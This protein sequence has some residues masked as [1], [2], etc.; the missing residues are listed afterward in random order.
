MSYQYNHSNSYQTYTNNAGS[1]SIDTGKEYNHTI[2]NNSGSASH[3]V[4][5]GTVGDII[6]GTVLQ[7]GDSPVVE[8]NGTPI[9]VRSDVL[10]SAKKGDQIYLRITG[11]TPSEITLK[12]V[13]QKELSITSRNGAMQTE[14]MKN[15]AQFVEHLKQSQTSQ[16]SGYQELSEEAV[17]LSENMSTEEKQKLR[18]MGIDLSS[19]NLTVVKNLLSQMRGQ[20]QEEELQKYIASVR[21]QI[22][23]E[24]PTAFED[25][26]LTAGSS[27]FDIQQLADE[28]NQILP[29]SEN[30][31]AYLIQNQLPLTMENLYKSE[32]T[33]AQRSQNHTVTDEAMKQMQPQIERTIQTAGLQVNE[34]TMQAA[35]FLLEKQLPLTSDSLTLYLAIQDIN[36]NGF[37]TSQLAEAA[38]DYIAEKNAFNQNES[39]NITSS[40]IPFEDNPSEDTTLTAP[41]ASDANSVTSGDLPIHAS[42]INLR[43][44]DLYFQSASKV[45]DQITNDLK[46]ITEDS[47]WAFAKTGLPYTLENL[48]SFSVSYSFSAA[49]TM[50]VEMNM[51]SA[52]T[53]HRQLE[54]IRLKMTWEA[55]FTLATEDIQIR[56]KE[57]T[58]VVEALKNQ[59]RDYYKQQFLANDVLP[60]N[61]NL[62]LVED[63]NTKLQELPGLPASAI[64]STL[65][66]GTFTIQR[67][68]ER[69][70]QEQ[71][72]LI[73]HSDTAHESVAAKV[74]SYETLMTAPRHDMGDSIQKA[75][76]NVN[77]LLE[78]M[79]L[80]IT[81]DNQRAVR[82][83]GYNQMELSP[84][85]IEQV[86]AA[87]Q[88]V[89]TLIRNL[90]PSVVLHMVQD[91]INPLHMPIDELN[92]LAQ[93][94]IQENDIADEGKYSQFLQKLDRRRAISS[95]ERKG[96]IGIYR[97]LNKIVKS[98]GKDIGTVVRNGQAVTLQ[99]LLTAH[100][101]NR[102]AGMDTSV[103]E[104]LGGIDVERKDTSI[105]DSIT[106]ATTKYNQG[107]TEQLFHQITPDI[108]DKMTEEA[109]AGSTL[110]EFFDT[111]KKQLTDESDIESN[112]ETRN[113]SSIFDDSVKEERLATANLEF[114]N[115]DIA[116]YQFMKEI[117]IFPSMTNIFMAKE[118]R[119]GNGRIF[120]ELS[121]D[122]EEITEQLEQLDEH[123]TSAEEMEQAYAELETR[124]TAEV[125]SADENGTITALDIQ[126]LKMIRSGLK[127][128]QK[129][130]RQN[131]FQIPF[132]V[133][134]QWNVMNLSIIEGG[135]TRGC[136]QADV[137]TGE[138]GT[139]STTLNWM[140]DHFEGSYYA[141]S[142][143]GTA[144]L[145]RTASTIADGL[146]DITSAS[147]KSNSETAPTTS[148]LYDMSKKLVLL[149]KHII[150]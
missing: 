49:Y 135:E 51:A 145:N 46:Q 139:I 3:S 116:D 94:Y 65:F 96:Y 132:S 140:E 81:E 15:T 104:N 113:N 130:S 108:I 55:S 98:K 68:H 53:A 4:N 103:D 109:S 50:T 134:G 25:G 84:E 36:E 143:A 124:K 122:S 67:L 86:K 87:D 73:R 106:E 22:I 85:N 115:L 131:R 1:V 78:E 7:A 148:E 80:P 19:A 129:M 8:M 99:N 133:N 63:T 24:N 5:L 127:I 136:I 100:R 6:T 18:Q 128:M 118:I 142:E 88:A 92:T 117:N 27:D 82:I 137:H 146:E 10:Q 121:E 56:A 38:T 83:L 79:D 48:S 150:R 77:D 90:Q 72:A 12:L 57:L 26:T 93:D 39:A 23:M 120:N 47:F 44:M 107:L 76:R 2:E 126:S 91:G 111:I 11:N 58:Q 42:K 64:A 45:A 60:S 35:K 20:A 52:I 40:D 101:S 30:Q 32:Y 97:L 61:D 59:E 114:L 123:L 149:M 37:K 144:L 75:F 21:K 33:G 9:P 16:N 14:I 95:E 112:A 138:F 141:D 147:N 66:T 102:N 69:G 41:T 110:E 74:K 70:L 62:K 13:D 31:T 28:A 71:A 119:Q 34:D 29:I 89:Q 105:S 125:H 17:L 54:E 43:K